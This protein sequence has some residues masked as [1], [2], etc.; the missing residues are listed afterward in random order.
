MMK[1]NIRI[2]MGIKKMCWQASGRDHS[3]VEGDDSG[4]VRTVAEKDMIALNS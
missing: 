3:G 1:K 4:W 2:D